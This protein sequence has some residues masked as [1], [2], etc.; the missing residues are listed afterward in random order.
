MPAK[1]C[2][3]G[4][5]K[6]WTTGAWICNERICLLLGNGLMLCVIPDQLNKTQK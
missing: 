1:Q 5:L 3:A 2:L 4:V 6:V